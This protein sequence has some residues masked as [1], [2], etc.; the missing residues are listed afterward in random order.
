MRLPWVSTLYEK[1][2]KEIVSIDGK[3]VRRTKE[4]S[5]GKKAIH[6][7]SAWANKNKLVLCQGFFDAFALFHY[8]LCLE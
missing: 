1:I 4:K 8:V 7:V 5:K 6:I 3:T 2:S